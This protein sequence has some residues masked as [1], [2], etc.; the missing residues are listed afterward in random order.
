M[1]RD[2]ERLAE[3]AQA[4]DSMGGLHA[5]L[6]RFVRR[7]GFAEFNLIGLSGFPANP[8]TD[9]PPYVTTT[10]EAWQRHY[11]ENGYVF[12]DPALAHCFASSLPLVPEAVLVDQLSPARREVMEAAVE[13]GMNNFVCIPIHGARGTLSSLSVFCA[14]GG[15]VFAEARRN[16]PALMASCAWVHEALCRLTGQSGAGVR[17]TD[18]ERECLLWVAQGKTSLDIGNILNLSE[19]TVKFHLQNAMCKLNTSSRGHAV[20][21]AASLGLIKI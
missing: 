8:E 20:A 21:R 10:S 4:C 13:F 1:I 6:D 18:R 11:I 7:A 14:D 5:L 15:K 17:L 16:L 3:E 12:K 2:V 19:R 9:L